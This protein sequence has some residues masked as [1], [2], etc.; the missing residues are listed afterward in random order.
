MSIEGKKATPMGQPQSRN[1]PN[2]FPAPRTYNAVEDFIDC[3]VEK[4]LGDKPAFIDPVRSLTYRD[5]QFA[6]N[7]MANLLGKLQIAKKSRIAMA[8]FDTV[9]FPIVYWG[10]IRAGVVP[11]CLNT[12]LTTEQYRYLL[13]DSECKCCI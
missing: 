1:S 6:T 4:G 12:L 5:L 8:M 11:V 2:A 13:A 7:K 9:D 3:N 10:S